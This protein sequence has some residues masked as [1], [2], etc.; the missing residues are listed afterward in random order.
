M[1]VA[2]IQTGGKQ[3]A[4]SKDSV[5]HVETIEGVTIGKNITFDN[6]LLVDDGTKTHVGS[7]FVAGAKVTAEVVAEGRDPKVTVIRYRQKSR[8]FKKK[9]HRQGFL[10]VKITDIK[11]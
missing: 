1:S 9:G 11:G 5:L 3:Y 4:V 2:I 7:P 8:Y 6:V 10:T